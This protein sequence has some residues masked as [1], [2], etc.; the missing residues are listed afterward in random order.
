MK[1]SKNMKTFRKCPKYINT[2]YLKSNNFQI[3]FVK[4]ILFRLLRKISSLLDCRCTINGDFKT[5]K[6]KQDKN[7]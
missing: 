2:L 1:I 3:Q 5:K 7:I 6:N 4:N